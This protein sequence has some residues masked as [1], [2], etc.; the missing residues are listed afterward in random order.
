[1]G[2]FW[3]VFGPLSILATPE[4][5][6]Y[7]SDCRET[8]RASSPSRPTGTFITHR[9]DHP[10]PQSSQ[11][12]AGHPPRDRAATEEARSLGLLFL[13][14]PTNTICIYIYNIIGVWVCMI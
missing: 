6:C 2:R 8:G 4:I 5:L 13:C 11:Q 9:G 7:N 10:P 1:L 14:P 12:A 3:T